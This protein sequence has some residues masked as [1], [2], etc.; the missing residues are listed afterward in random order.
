MKPFDRTVNLLGVFVPFIALVA[1]APVAWHYELLSW[2]D[3][4]IFT[5]MYLVAG[6]GIT[7]GYHRLLTHRSFQTFKSVEYAFAIAGELAVEGS[8]LDWVADHRKHHAHTDVEGDPHSPHVEYRGLRGWWHAHVGWTWRNH[9]LA[10]HERYAKDLTEDR[11]MRFI[12][13][14]TPVWAV[15]SFALPFGLG[16]ALTGTVIG[17][18]T[19][20]LWGGLIRLVMLHHV[21]WSINSVCHI[22][23]TRR[24]VVDETG[25]ET[26]AFYEESRDEAGDVAERAIVNRDGSTIHSEYAASRQAGFDERHTVTTSEGDKVT[27]ETIERTQT[28]R[29]GGPDGEIVGRTVWTPGGPEPDAT[30]QPAFAPLAV[31]PALIIGGAILFNWQSS[32]NGDGQQAVTAF[33]ANE[34]RPSSPNLLDLR[35][36]GRVSQEEAEAACK[37]LPDLQ[38]RLDDVVARA[39]SVK[40]YPFGCSL[41]DLCS[42]ASQ[43]A[44]RRDGP[45][46]LAC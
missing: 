37:C 35:F 38:V 9:G 7:I 46:G 17:G 26:W 11:G 16:V 44:D 24:F 22:F 30:I 3:I 13:Y 8:P 29:I 36:A 4:V 28:M 43:R 6:F 23:G 25:E 18:L 40:D 20:L 1:L 15:V 5:V 32:Q 12:H 21:T 19:G 14:T 34:Y 31:A 2:Q 10:E 42:P 41:R 33:E 45:R 27:F 39:G